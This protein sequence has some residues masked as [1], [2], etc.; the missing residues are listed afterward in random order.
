MRHSAFVTAA[1]AAAS[2]A[3]LPRPALAETVHVQLSSYEEVPALLGGE[4][5]I[6]G[7]HQ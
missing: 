7:I 4:R 5:I 1:L 3:P 2:I 6:P